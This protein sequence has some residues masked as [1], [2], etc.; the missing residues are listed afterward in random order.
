M[1]GMSDLPLDALLKPALSIYITQGQAPFAFTAFYCFAA[2]MPTLLLYYASVQ[3][4]KCRVDKHEL[5]HIVNLL[6]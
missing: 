4:R 3:I 2:C 1:C 6:L 5:L